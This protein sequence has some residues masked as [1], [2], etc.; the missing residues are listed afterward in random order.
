MVIPTKATGQRSNSWAGDRQPSSSH[1]LQP[2]TLLQWAWKLQ[3]WNMRMS[4]PGLPHMWG[5]QLKPSLPWGP[6]DPL[7]SP[8][9]AC[10]C[11][12]HLLEDCSANWH[13]WKGN[14]Q[15]TVTVKSLIM[16]LTFLGKK[17]AKTSH[18]LLGLQNTKMKCICPYGEQRILHTCVLEVSG[19][20]L[21][22]QPPQLSHRLLGACD[23]ICGWAWTRRE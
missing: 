8:I 5:Q 11:H 1:H 14:V 4:R 22:R 12:Q 23:R 16:A 18:Q 19:G 6:R 7:L 17:K 21:S 2:T 9:S 15:T 3:G 20:I 13:Q 10:L